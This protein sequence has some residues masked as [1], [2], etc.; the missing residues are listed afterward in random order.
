MV[1][2]LLL[3]KKL[4]KTIHE[5]RSG[6]LGY[7][8]PI[9]NWL[10][11]KHL[12]F[13]ARRGGYKFRLGDKLPAELYRLDCECME[14]VFTRHCKDL[15]TSVEPEHGFRKSIYIIITHCDQKEVCICFWRGTPLNRIVE[16]LMQFPTRDLECVVFIADD[17]NRFWYTQETARIFKC[18]VMLNAPLS[19]SAVLQTRS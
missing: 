19:I 16:M 14:K 10:F 9:H 13:K 11:I 17:D 4:R 2:N 7:Y 1:S 6:L 3:K 5:L 8:A 12:A 15:K 18:A